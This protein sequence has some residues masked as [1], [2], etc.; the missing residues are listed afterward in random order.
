MPKVIIFAGA[1]GSGKTTLA[2]TLIEPRLKFI[3]AD[4]IKDTEKLSDVDAGKKA[5]RL[6]DE[7]ISKGLDFSFETTMSGMGLLKRFKNLQSKKYSISIFYLFVC[8]VAL[9]TERI[10]ERIKKGG[11]PVAEVAI[12]RRYYRSAVNFWNI[13]KSIAE[14]WIIINNSEFKYKHVA[15]GHGNSFIIIDR[16]EFDKF[17]EVL[18]YEKKKK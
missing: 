9:L 5:L 16:G 13:Y 17:K 2:N 1:N 8:P 14:E 12:V 6:I 7:Y 18:N 10:K 11:H 15:I 4:Y 3:N